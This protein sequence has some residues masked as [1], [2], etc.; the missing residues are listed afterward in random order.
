VTVPRSED[1]TPD[2]DNAPLRVYGVLEPAGREVFC[3]P[4]TAKRVVAVLARVGA[5]VAAGQALVQLEADVESAAVRVAEGTVEEARP[6]VALAVDEVDRLTRRV[7][8][9]AVSQ[10]ELSRAVL[11][12]ELEKRGLDTSLAALEL[13]RAELV[14]LTLRAPC[15]GRIYRPDV[16]IGG[17][18]TPQDY[19]RIVVGPKERWVRLFVEVFRL[20]RVQLGDRVAVRDAETLVE[21]GTG[22]VVELLPY[23]GSRD[24]R[25]EDRRERLDTK[26]GQATCASSRNATRRSACWCFVSADANV[27]SSAVMHRARSRKVACRVKCE[28]GLDTCRRPLTLV[29]R[30]SPRSRLLARRSGT[31]AIGWA[32]SFRS[33]AADGIGGRRGKLDYSNPGRSAMEVAATTASRLSRRWSA[34]RPVPIAREVGA[35]P[36]G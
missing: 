34:L 8:A 11:T 29:D 36:G 4:P 32:W 7:F 23:V 19:A 6:R 5:A 10:A 21:I 22:S 12:L 13:R 2:F 14:Q 1:R 31:V 3:G 15:A 20:N 17:L 35:R 30:L 25:T 26:Y 18:L 28:L 16:R 9:N 24:F 27:R 33:L